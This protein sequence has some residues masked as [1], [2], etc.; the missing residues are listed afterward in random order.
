MEEIS[1]NVVGRPRPPTFRREQA[2]HG[3]SEDRYSR[4]RNTT[5]AA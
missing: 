2:S 1:Q 3:P 4:I 5:E